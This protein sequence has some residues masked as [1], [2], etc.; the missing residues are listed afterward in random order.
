VRPDPLAARAPAQGL[1]D[2]I[3][4]LLAELGLEFSILRQHGHPRCPV[5]RCGRLTVTTTKC[6]PVGL[7]I[8]RL[9]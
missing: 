3:L 4:L 5:R 2:L 7:R 9:A 6:Q 8:I 1:L